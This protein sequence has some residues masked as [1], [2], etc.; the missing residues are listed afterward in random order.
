MDICKIPTRVCSWGVGCPLSEASV[1]AQG[2]HA[3]YSS[4]EQPHTKA[5]AQMLRSRMKLSKQD[6]VL[7]LLVIIDSIPALL[8]HNQMCQFINVPAASC[9]EA[10]ISPHSFPALALLF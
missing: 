8:S 5:R 1:V 7:T 4:R 3:A 9:D 10:D 6:L 2:A